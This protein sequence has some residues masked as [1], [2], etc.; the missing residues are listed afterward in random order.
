ML[1]DYNA[2]DGSVFRLNLRVLGGAPGSALWQLLVDDAG[3]ARRAELA[4]LIRDGSKL[5]L[6]EHEAHRGAAA[7]ALGQL[8]GGPAVQLV[9]GHGPWAW[10]IGAAPPAP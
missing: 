9:L 4:P 2:V 5:L 1:Q 3:E 8:R 6:S 7:A 10:A